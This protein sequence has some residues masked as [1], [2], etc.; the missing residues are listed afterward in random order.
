MSYSRYSMYRT[1]AEMMPIFL[2]REAHHQHL[3]VVSFILAFPRILEPELSHGLEDISE[4]V[5]RVARPLYR[6]Y[7]SCK[8]AF[9]SPCEKEEWVAAVWSEA[10]GRSGESLRPL[11]QD[12]GASVIFFCQMWHDFM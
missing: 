10:C 4:T 1:E 8:D 9:P 7:L 2:A 12:E 11:P 6:C 3:P 5:M